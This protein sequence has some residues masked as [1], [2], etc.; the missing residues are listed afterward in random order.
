MTRTEYR[1]Q[2]TGKTP[3]HV[4]AVKLGANLHNLRYSDINTAANLRI[5][6]DYRAAHLTIDEART[7]LHSWLLPQSS[8]YQYHLPDNTG[9]ITLLAREVRRV[10]EEQI[11]IVAKI[12]T[13]PLASSESRPTWDNCR[14]RLTIG[15]RTLITEY[16]EEVD[17]GERRN[18]QWPAHTTRSYTTRLLRRDYATPLSARTI[19]SRHIYGEQLIWDA[20][21][22]R[23]ISHDAR[24]HWWTR[25]ITELLGAEAA[26]LYSY[27][28]EP[29]R[30]YKIINQNGCLRSVYNP[31]YC[32]TVGEWSVNPAKPDHEG[33]LYAYPTQEQAI[34]AAHV[35]EVFNAARVAGKTLVLCEC[36][37]RGRRIQYQNGKCAWSELRIDR[38]IEPIAHS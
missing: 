26:N 35:G 27:L 6:W 14:V 24:G 5:V 28:P 1:N 8:R 17:W 3:T 20:I 23:T 2:R 12:A 13:I 18:P 4:E 31:D 9:R 36:T 11:K 34:E 32:Y 15:D 29:S 16:H 33:G 7:K 10:H 19:S 22:E 30:A 25:I 37:A 38:V 21:T